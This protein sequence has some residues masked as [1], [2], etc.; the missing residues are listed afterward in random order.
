MN[1]L[2]IIS[3]SVLFSACI[4]TS[5][6]TGTS[7]KPT[8]EQNDIKE[9]L[10]ELIVRH[11]EG[12]LSIPG[13]EKYDYKT[14]EADLN[15]DDSLDIIIAVNQL[16][17]AINEA[18]EQGNTAKRAELG[19]IGNYNH[20]FYLDGKTKQISPPIAVPSSPHAQLKISFENI[21]SEAYKDI[22]VDFRIRNSCFRRFFTILHKTP[23]QTFEQKL[24]DGLGDIKTEA[25]TIKYE[26]GS[27]SLAKDILIYRGTLENVTINRPLDVYQINPSIKETDELERRWFFNANTLKY[28]TMKE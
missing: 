18:I 17:K 8:E 13:T 19:Y 24:F 21:R 5:G 1:Y 6:D 25:F 23:R 3:I 7:S 15:G 20:V 11:I 10:D 26:K 16:E 2:H 22:L 4:D 12:T 28:F 27:Y 14:F 9:T